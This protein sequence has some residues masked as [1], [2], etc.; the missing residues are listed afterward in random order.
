MTPN[1]RNERWMPI[2]FRNEAAAPPCR[3]IMSDGELQPGCEMPQLAPPPE[4]EDRRAWELRKPPISSA[5]GV[6]YLTRS[7]RR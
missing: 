7:E 1:K 5:G 6:S 2:P 3:Q 4:E